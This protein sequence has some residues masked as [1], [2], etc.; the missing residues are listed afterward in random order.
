MTC[1]VCEKQISVGMGSRQNLV[2]QHRPGKSKACKQN[3]KKKK[4]TSAHQQ[5]QL[6]LPSFFIK[7]PKVV[8]PPTVPMPGPV[9]AYAI[10]SVSHLP[11]T[12]TTE[13]TPRQVPP[14]PNTHSVNILAALEKAVESLPVLPEQV[15]PTKSQYFLRMS[16]WIWPKRTHG[17]TLTQC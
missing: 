6:E 4:K 13:L 12:H 16:P 3:L 11:A 14:A 1:P 17:N 15:N 10:E 7:Q 8:I 9:I 5:S 2:K